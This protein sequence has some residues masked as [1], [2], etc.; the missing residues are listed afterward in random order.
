MD[1]FT[2]VVPTPRSAPGSVLSEAYGIN[3]NGQVVGYYS[4]GAHSFRFLYSG[5]VYTTLL[6]PG[7]P[8]AYA[9]GINDNG[10]IVGVAFNPYFGATPLPATLPL[11]ATGLGALGLLGWRRKRKGTA[12]TREGRSWSFCGSG[13]IGSLVWRGR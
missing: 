13:I 6:D 11:F 10:Q 1:I 2:V 12:G 4:D 5:G 7:N 8:D 3:N 9:Y